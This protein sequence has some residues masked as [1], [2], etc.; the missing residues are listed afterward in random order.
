MEYWRQFSPDMLR[1]SA[2]HR[3]CVVLN[4]ENGC[5]GECLAG[6]SQYETTEYPELQA[7]PFQ[8]G[9]YVIE[10]NGHA[11]VDGE[12]FPISAGMSF[13]VPAGK[14]HGLRSGEGEA[15]VR[16]FWFHSA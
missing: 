10:G 13:L 16:V 3:S 1:E 11:L 5:V 6:I 12:E 8:E 15:F 9:F 14:T 4:A 7:H 2:G